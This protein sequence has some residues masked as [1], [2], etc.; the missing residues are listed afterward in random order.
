FKSTLLKGKY[1]RNAIEKK[2]IHKNGSIIYANLTATLVRN[3]N[4][5]P[6]YFVSVTEDVTEKKKAEELLKR[7][8][9]EKEILLKEIHHRVKNNLQIISSIL[10]LQSS[11]LNDKR[12]INI[13]K[14]SQDRIKSMAFIHESLYQTKDF[15]SINISEYI[16]NL[17]KNLVYSFGTECSFVNLK[18]DTDNIDLSLDTAIPCGLIINELVSNSLKYA[19]PDNHKGEIKITLKQKNKRL[20]LTIAD[21]GVGL[22]SG[23]NFKKTE[24]LGLQLV[25]TLVE[26]VNG[27]ITKMNVKGTK[28]IITLAAKPKPL[29]K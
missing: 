10:S 16:E 6:D 12:T 1:S 11:Y 8:L 15:S 24:S 25:N 3:Q 19:F 18:L 5:D 14:E 7:S 20:I 4:G 17:S 26:Q 27:D 23:L 29:N 2:Y 13:L 22:P 28:F 21:N 9:Q